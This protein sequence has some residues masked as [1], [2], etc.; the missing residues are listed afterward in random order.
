MIWLPLELDLTPKTYQWVLVDECQDLNTAQYELVRK[1]VSSGGRM[2]FVGDRRQAIYAFAGAD[3]HSFDRI[4]ED[5]QPT[6]LPLSV[7]YRCPTK[8][9]ELAR[10]LCPQIE[11]H[12]GACEGDV[13]TIQEAGIQTILRAGDMVLC[14]VNA[15]LLGLCYRLLRHGIRACVRG[16]AVGEG[17]VAAVGAVMS[18]DANFANFSDAVT[19]WQEDEAD[20]IVARGGRDWV[21]EGRMEALHDKAECLR[22]LYASCRPSSPEALCEAIA[23][24]FSDAHPAVELSSIHRA[25][26][27]ERAR[28]FILEPERLRN[29]RGSNPEQLEQEH[30]LHYVAL[31]RAKRS[32]FFVTKPSRSPEDPAEE[33]SAF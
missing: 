19:R 15:P 18:F 31:T 16:R 20:R 23:S 30:N 14:R 21:V 12:E 26:G 5:M 22:I 28:V 9:V 25:K 33:R 11:A 6:Q 8:I 7:C 3:A 24:L 13:S 2:V 4:M 1:C 27:L 29:P 10:V 17:L 32:L